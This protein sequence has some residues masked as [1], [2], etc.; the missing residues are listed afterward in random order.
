MNGE[1]KTATNKKNKKNLT[2]KCTSLVHT[3]THLYHYRIVIVL[4]HDGFK[5]GSVSSSQRRLFG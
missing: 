3:H 5:D 2:D 1:T 4:E